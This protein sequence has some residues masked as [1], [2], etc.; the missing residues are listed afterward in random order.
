MK[1]QILMK[2]QGSEQGLITKDSS[3]CKND[4]VLINS[5]G[6][7]REKDENGKSILRI[8]IDKD[9]DHS[10]PFISDA[11]KHD[12]KI[13]V[14]IKYSVEN[15]KPSIFNYK[16]A[17]I[18]KINTLFCADDFNPIDGFSGRKGIPYEVIQI[19]SYE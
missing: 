17:I 19:I 14:T 8:T 5:I 16:N 4:A 1:R 11:I 3:N 10:T 18:D 7:S 6:L 12:E 9:I 2:I 13:D 15:E